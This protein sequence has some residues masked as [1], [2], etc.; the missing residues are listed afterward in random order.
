MERQRDYQRYSQRHRPLERV[1]TGQH[2]DAV[3]LPRR[4]DLLLSTPGRRVMEKMCN[5]C[6][7]RPYADEIGLRCDSDG[8]RY[9]CGVNCPEDRSL[10][11]NTGKYQREKTGYRVSNG[12]GRF[13][14]V[15]CGPYTTQT[16]HPPTAPTAAA[17]LRNW[18]GTSSP[19]TSRE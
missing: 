3:R 6:P 8:E 18:K 2:A 1:S 7:Y 19:S 13:R 10:V 15:S 5:Q 12:V 9:V 14:R 16:A 4:H 11:I 17:G